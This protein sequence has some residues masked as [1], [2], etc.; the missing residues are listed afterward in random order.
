MLSRSITIDRSVD[1]S[2]GQSHLYAPEVEECWRCLTRFR[3]K[4]KEL[5]FYL[6]VL[7]QKSFRECCSISQ[8]KW[9]YNQIHKNSYQDPNR[10]K[11]VLKV[12]WRECVDVD[13]I[14]DR[15]S[16]HAT[17][18]STRAWSEN[19]VTCRL[20]SGMLLPTSLRNVHCY[21][22]TAGNFRVSSATLWGCQTLAVPKSLSTLRNWWWR[23]ILASTA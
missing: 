5:S 8:A 17:L 19:G 2:R 1:P 20:S 3:V 16:I 7:E 15:C 18:S 12:V 10:V 14:V 23:P 11:W 6:W 22:Y 4:F 9:N 21:Q 13:K